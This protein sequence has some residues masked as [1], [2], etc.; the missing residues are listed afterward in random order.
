MK[1]IKIL[2][3][4][5]IQQKTRR[6]AYQIVE[7]NYDESELI[8]IGIKPNGFEYAGQ[9]KKEIEAIDNIKVALIELSLN[10]AKPLE[11]SIVLELGKKTLDNKTVIIVDD[12]ANTGKTLYYALKPVM[13]FLPK[14]VQAAVL[15]DRQHKL[16]PVSPDFVGLSLSTTLQEHI[17]VEFDGK[18]KGAAYLT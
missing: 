16:F 10:K 11:D 5:E 14:K 6:I 13:G 1:K 2:S 7:D 4:E 12:V 15:V 3:A 18:G 17:L 9:L 8:L